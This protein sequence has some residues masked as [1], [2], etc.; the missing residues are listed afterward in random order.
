[1]R[2]CFL[3]ACRRRLRQQSA[4]PPPHWGVL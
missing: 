1:M 2:L 3:I 4:A